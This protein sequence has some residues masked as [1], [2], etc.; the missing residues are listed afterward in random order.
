MKAR[1]HSLKTA[2]LSGASVAVL[3]SLC[4]VHA[5]GRGKRVFP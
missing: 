2:L 3:G 4:V 5:E 1:W